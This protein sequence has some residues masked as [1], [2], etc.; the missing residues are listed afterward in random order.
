MYS[1]FKF[2]NTY[3]KIIQQNSENP[4]IIYWNKLQICVEF[5]KVFENIWYSFTK[6]S[7]KILLHFKNPIIFEFDDFWSV[8]NPSEIEKV[9][10]MFQDN[11]EQQKRELDIV[12]PLDSILEV[13][14]YL[15]SYLIGFIHNNEPSLLKKLAKSKE[16]IWH[17]EF[18]NL[19]YNT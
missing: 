15:N 7:D 17:I 16:F 18:E 2:S 12:I 5:A 11:T 6:S 10:K 13:A 3:I 9:N 19:R 8:I 14:I 1:Q 4:L